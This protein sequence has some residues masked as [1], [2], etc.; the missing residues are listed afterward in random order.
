MS[1]R[2]DI[3]ISDNG[4]RDKRSGTTWPEECMALSQHAENLQVTN[5]NSNEGRVIPSYNMDFP[6]ACL[7]L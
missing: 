6:L 1:Q 7:L 2:A 4:T 5:Y 3:P